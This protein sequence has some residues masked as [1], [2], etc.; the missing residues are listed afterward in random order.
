MRL[1]LAITTAALLAGCASN[2]YSKVPEPTGDWV[3][4]NPPSLTA[5]V[6][7]APLPMPT[8]RAGV[9]QAVRASWASR[10]AQQ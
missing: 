1:V 2:E 8:T 7:P 9:R 3:A 4:A 6:A 10:I 5:P